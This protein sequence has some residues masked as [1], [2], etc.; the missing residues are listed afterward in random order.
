MMIGKSLGA[1]GLPSPITPASEAAVEN[2]KPKANG[3]P[4]LF[5]SPSR[6]VST[7]SSYLGSDESKSNTQA[8]KV[9]NYAESGDEDEDED[10]FNPSQASRTRG[11]ALK[12]RKTTQTE[13]EDEFGGGG[14]WEVEDFIEEGK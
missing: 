7:L 8:K 13:D 2:A 4:L 5:D 3:L 12:R 11:R 1:N 9:V 6:K 10:A 14:D